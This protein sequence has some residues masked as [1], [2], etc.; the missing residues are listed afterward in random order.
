MLYPNGSRTR[1]YVSSPYGP[2][3]PRVGISS[4][5][6]G[7]DLT[8]FTAI[9]AV[10]AG[11]VTFAGWMND[12]A[13]Y[14]IVIDHGAGVSSVYMHNAAHHVRSRDR[15]VAGQEI[16]VMGRTGNA[17]G[18]CCHLEIRIRGKS[19]DPLPY[20][21]ARLT[22]TAGGSTRPPAQ[23]EEEETMYIANVK[24]GHTFYLVLGKSAHKLASGSGARG[25]GIPILNYPDD[26]AVAWLKAG[27]VTGID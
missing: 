2:R 9:H 7:A 19:T 14:T 16:A 6:H 22:T 3:D 8:G 5:H 24:N 1:P 21:A 27:G 17:S 20:I 13:G 15:V 25:S 26:T 12:A 4:M 10:A 18:K 23:E 11:R